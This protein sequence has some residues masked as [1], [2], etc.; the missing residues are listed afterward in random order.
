MRQI[1]E[2]TLIAERYEIGAHL[3]SGGMGV[4]YEARDRARQNA[5][6]ALKILKAPHENEQSRLRFEEEV[7][8]ASKLSSPHIVQIYGTGQLPDERPFVVMELLH[9]AP[10]LDII[11][12]ER[13]LDVERVL[14]IARGLLLALRVAHDGGVVHRDLK[15]ANVYVSSSAEGDV[16]KILDF[17]IAKDLSRSEDLGL[18]RTGMLVGTPTYMSPERFSANE[19]VTPST[20]LYAV[21]LMLY[22]MLTGEPL[23]YA[24]HPA[25][26]PEMRRMPKP[27]QICWLHL[28]LVP[29][30]VMAPDPL[31]DLIMRLLGKTPQERPS[32]REA[33]Q[34]VMRLLADYGW[35]QPEETSSLPGALFEEITAAGVTRAQARAGRAPEGGGGVGEVGEVGEMG[36][37]H[38]EGSAPPRGGS[39]VSVQ[40]LALTPLALRALHDELDRAVREHEGLP[41]SEPLPLSESL[42]LSEPLSESLPRTLPLVGPMVESIFEG[43]EVRRASAQTVLLPTISAQVEA[44]APAAPSPAP[45]QPTPQPTTAPASPPLSPAHLRERLM[46]LVYVL[47]GALISYVVLRFL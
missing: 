7:R 41:L 23:V 39:G 37:V 10:L 21:G 6:C 9:G 22:R 30:R 5:R 18:T 43:E 3:G 4:V 42:P 27:L 8:C 15:P 12:L 46:P 20:D 24:E 1:L 2:N 32:A 26:P 14:H 47:L 11:Q 36:E 13:R 19:R 35:S 45:P 38:D 33:L 40:T 29:P 31:A 25:L 44:R 28:H 34:V 16:V 17:G